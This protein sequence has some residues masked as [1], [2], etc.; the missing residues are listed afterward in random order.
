MTAAPSIVL[1]HV[2]AHGVAV[3]PEG[4]RRLCAPVRGRVVLVV[5]IAGPRVGHRQDEHRLVPDM[6][7]VHARDH[8]RGSVLIVHGYTVLRPAACSKARFT[9]VC[10]IWIL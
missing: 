9:A 2:R 10:V 8:A 3:R 6:L 7:A 4:R 1:T 5:E